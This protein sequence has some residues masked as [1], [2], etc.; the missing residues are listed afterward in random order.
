MD[1]VMQ[2]EH[3]HAAWTW[4]CSMNIDMQHGL[5]H[6]AFPSSCPCL[7]WD[8]FTLVFFI[9]QLLLVLWDM[10]RKDFEFFWIFKELILVAID[11]PLYSPTGS[12]TSPV[13]SPQWSHDSLV[14]S[15]P[16]SQD[17]PVMNTL[18]SWPK[19]VYKKVVGA[20]Y[21]RKSR[22]ACG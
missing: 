13:Y 9:K 22:L 20:K 5:N 11:S 8:F 6:A 2:H 1:M 18:R 19:L 3:G 15:S 17:S 7:S 10:H 16:G 4:S 12:R 14:Y 21:F